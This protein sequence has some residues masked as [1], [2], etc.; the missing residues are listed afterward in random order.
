MVA[1]HKNTDFG[2]P[3]AP[4][5]AIKDLEAGDG[6]S[7]KS[8]V[9]AHAGGGQASATQLDEVFSSVDTV[10]TAADSVKLPKAKAGMFRVAKNTSANSMNVYP[11]T[12]EAINALGANAAYAV[13][14]VKA[15]I[16]FCPVD[17]QWQTILTA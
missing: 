10:A 12:G 1:R 9:V 6:F 13:A 3:S 7:A 2:M 14:T 5:K 11:A 17:G 4:A 8:G 16:F 15:V